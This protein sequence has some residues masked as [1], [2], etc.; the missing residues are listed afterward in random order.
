MSRDLQKV[1]YLG[2]EVAPVVLQL[3]AGSR[4]AVAE[5]GLDETVVGQVVWRVK[6]PQEAKVKNEGQGQV[7]VEEEQ[8]QEKAFLGLNGLKEEQKEPGFRS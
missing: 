2:A 5:A 6:V 4:P 1:L 3:A 7:K 8:I